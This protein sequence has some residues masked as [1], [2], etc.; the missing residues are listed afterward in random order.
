MRGTLRIERLFVYLQIDM[1]SFTAPAGGRHSSHSTQQKKP[2]AKYSD[3]KK[4]LLLGLCAACAGT[5]ISQS[6]INSAGRLMIEE[7]TSASAPDGTGKRMAAPRQTVVS[8][9]VTMEKGADPE[10]LTQYG[11]ELGSKAGDMV[12][13]KATIDVIEKLAE[14]EEVSS[15]SFGTRSTPFMDKAR[16]ASN[17]D[18]IHTGSADG[19]AG[20][21]YTGK[22]V[23]VGLYDT[24]LDPNH[25]AFRDATGK[26]RVNAIYVTRDNPNESQEITDPDDIAVFTTEEQSESHGTHVL[27]IIAG[28][29]GVEGEYRE[30]QSATTGAMPFHG[31]APGSDIIVGCGD[32][33]N[34]CILDGLAKVIERGKTLGKPMVMN[35]S[36]GNNSG[37]HDPNSTEG[38]FLDELGKQAIICISAGNEGDNPMAL[39]QR[40]TAR[41]KKLNTFIVP[42]SQP[43]AMLAYTAEFWADN[44]DEFTLSLV[45]YDKV[46]EKIIDSKEIG[47]LKGRTAGWDPSSSSVFGKNFTESS[48]IRV[49]SD[50]DKSTG[51]YNVYMQG[52]MTPKGTPTCVFGVNITGKSGN[53]VFGYV[54][55]LR[56]SQDNAV[57]SAEKVAGYANGTTD[58]T[59]NG[60]GCGHNMISVGAYVSR[61]TAPYIGSG[62]Y[63]GGGTQGDIASFSSYGELADGRRLPHVCAPGA[64]I[65]S[66]VSSYWVKNNGF[67]KDRTN[68][69]STSFGRESYYYPMQ[70]TS[71]SSPFAAGTIALWLEA[72][73]EMTV[74]QC[75]D[76][77]NESSVKD[78]Y[79]NK[80][81]NAQRW[82]AG[83]IDALAGLKLAITRSASLNSVGA[84]DPSKSL[85]VEELGGKRFSVFMGGTD[86]FTANL[87]S[88]QGALV[89]SVVSDNDTA[90]LDASSLG[91][92]IYVLEVQG[93]N[94]HASRKIVVK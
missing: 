53:T 50:V 82:G 16:E 42:Q 79:V 71:M 51:R 13:V 77:I 43:Q 75:L 76:I 66:S 34:T 80:A 7:Y 68:G 85:I 24:G 39:K 22:G 52:T 5:A 23:V 26:S 28:S 29:Q 93:K 30:G 31:V 47:N 73:P 49:T 18:G 56:S 4:I 6:K 14:L 21:A 41:N 25:A 86:K 57:F 78:R 15:I 61:T 32:F 65:V 81:E 11:C 3:M 91:E 20:H 27:G 38:K 60:F 89:A 90:E 40:F 46:T 44:A 63:V 35:L 64:Q 10:I 9:I 37:S 45:I 12:I 72:W 17:V 92:G 54:N 70:G 74:S 88:M 69:L 48:Y 84:D 59:I 67:S 94:V 33:Y 83:K 62:A 36:L 58:G 2:E 55:T 8:A 19:L 1:Q 87:Y